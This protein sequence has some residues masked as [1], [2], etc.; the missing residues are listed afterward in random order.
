MAA[1]ILEY[2]PYGALCAVVFGVL[3]KLNKGGYNGRQLP[4]PDDNAAPP[5]DKE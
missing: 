5:K 3:K 4:K 1:L 2:L